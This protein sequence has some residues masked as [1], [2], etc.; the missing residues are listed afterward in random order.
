MVVVV[1]DFGAVIVGPI[2]YLARHPAIDHV[3]GAAFERR[4]QF[5]PAGWVV[6]FDFRRPRIDVV[7]Q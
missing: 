3:N 1:D 2:Q 4:H 5:V 6:F 7:F